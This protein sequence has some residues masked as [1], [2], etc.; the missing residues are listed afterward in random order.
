MKHA[1]VSL[2]LVIAASAATFAAAQD[3][4]GRGPPKVNPYIIV[5]G[6]LPS[7]WPGTVPMPKLSEPAQR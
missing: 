4:S 1:I 3:G 6:P 7:K 5:I 2:F